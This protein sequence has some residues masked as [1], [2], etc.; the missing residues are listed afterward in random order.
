M[1]AVSSKI[2]LDDDDS[3]VI[4]AVCFPKIPKWKAAT[5]PQAREHFIGLL[6]KVLYLF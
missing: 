5:F 3:N 2:D 6:A 4:I 1:S